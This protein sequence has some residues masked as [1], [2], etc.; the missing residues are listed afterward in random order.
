MRQ[1][2]GTFDQ[3]LS[4]DENNRDKSNRLSSFLS[5]TTPQIDYFDVF[6]KTYSKKNPRKA[7][8]PS[9]VLFTHLAY[10][11]QDLGDGVFVAVWEVEY[12]T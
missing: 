4:F 3:F 12:R 6:D 5:G 1:A 9:D 11:K 2:T 10:I 8:V 7:L